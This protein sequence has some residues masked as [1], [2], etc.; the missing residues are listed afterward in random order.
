M[1]D[2]QAEILSLAQRVLGSDIADL[3]TGERGVVLEVRALHQKID[4]MSAVLDQLAGA[5]GAPGSG[6]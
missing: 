5:D 4:R 1:D 6:G 2:G 3:P